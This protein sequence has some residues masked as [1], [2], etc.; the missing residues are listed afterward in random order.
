[1]LVVVCL[2][3]AGLYDYLLYRKSS[4]WNKQQRILLSTIRFS[5]AFIILLLLL[6]PIIRQI[7]NYFEKPIVV[8]A[9]D[10]SS[11]LAVVLDS[12]KLEDIKKSIDSIHSGLISNNYQIEVR[13]FSGIHAT[14]AELEFNEQTTNIN[15]LLTSVENDYENRNLADVI[16]LS[17]GIYNSGISPNFANYNF[18]LHTI[19]TG[20]TIP[21]KDL[22]IKELKYNK[23]SYQGNQFPIIAEIENR[24][25]I[26]ESITISLYNSG[27][28]LDQKSLL[29]TEEEGIKAVEFL[30]NANNK[31]LQ[32]Y[33][34][35]ID[36]KRNEFNTENNN[37][38]AY[39]DII[40]GKERVLMI[41]AIKGAIETN[42]N[43]EFNL[44]IPG[45]NKEPK[46]EYDL[47]IYHQFPDSRGI[48]NAWFEKNK[49]TP[50]WIITTAKSNYKTLNEIIP[51]AQVQLLGNE[52]DAITAS[53]NEGFSSFN[54]L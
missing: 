31:G 37:A 18:I 34:I 4:T 32:R 53:F 42:S 36:Q 40:D 47:I 49:T 52:T 39:I 41:K 51:F 21:K 22:L 38:H 23:I 6:S 11:S 48:L 46:G 25:F 50:Y 2:I 54:S 7:E 44:F 3:F 45:L 8:I 1:M 16:L 10:N 20:D 13:S 27:K 24:G 26:N 15:E 28:K 19:G 43:Y 14:S 12:V 5:V 30:V 29:L 33:S 17:D 9:V 35:S